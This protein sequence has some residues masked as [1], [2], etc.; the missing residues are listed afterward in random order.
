MTGVQTCALPIYL[1]ASTLLL[2]SRELS[3]EVSVEGYVES[4][5]DIGIGRVVHFSFENGQIRCDAGVS[6]GLIGVGIADVT[7][8]VVWNGEGYELGPVSEL[9]P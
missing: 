3:L 7:A 6:A 1:E 2:T 9:R 8:P 5:E 4:V